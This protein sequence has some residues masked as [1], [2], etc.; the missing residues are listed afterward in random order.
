VSP[1]DEPTAAPAVSPRKAARSLVTQ[2]LIAELVIVALVGVFA[3]AGL[4]WTSASVIR[5]NLSHWASQWAGEL[6]ELGAPLYHDEREAVLG[7]E[8]FVAKYPEIDRVTWYRA[9]GSALTALD[10]TGVVDAAVAPLDPGLRAELAAKAG[11]DAPYLLTEDLTD[12]VR[13]RLSGPIRT[14][15]LAG[16][17]LFGFDPAAAPTSAELVGFVSVDIDFSAYE[18]AFLPRLALASGAL[19][20]LLGV[21]WACGRWF[22]KRALAPLSAL[23]QPLARLAAGDM[24]VQFPSSPHAELQAIVTALGDTI[25]A[26]HRRERHLLHLASHD[27]LT[28]LHN[29]HK[30]IEALDAEIA[31]CAAGKRRSALFF[32]DLDQFKYVNDTCGH[33]A[34]DEL[35]KLASRQI[36]HGVRAD[37]LVARFGGDEFVVLLRDVSRNDAKIVA[38]QVLELMRSL[39]H[40]EQDRVFHLQCSIGIAAINGH[41]FSAHE[42]IAQADIACQTAKQRGRNRVEVYS[43]AEKRSEQMAKDVDWM[44]SIRTALDNDGFVLYYQPLLHI[45]SGDVTH[46]EA[47]LRLKTEQG[48][49]SP[50]TFLPAA[51]RFGLMADIDRWVIARAVRSLAEFGAADA[52]LSL[53]VNL[54]SFAFENDDLGAYVRYLL[55]EHGVSGDKLTFEITEQLAVRF[56][57]KTDRQ[58]A[59]LRDLGCRIAIDDFGTGYSSFSYLKR[60]PVDFLKID[61]SFI[62]GLP[63]DR[64]DQSMVRMVGEV[65]RAAGMQTVAEYVHSAAALSL[66]AKYG[67]DYAQGFFIGRPAPKPQQVEIATPRAVNDDRE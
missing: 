12:G 26:L 3:L 50:Q 17:G 55:R 15:T 19:L 65:A 16:D 51:A 4:A 33:A 35:L 22:L 37:D 1:T 52:S 59:S 64:V 11:V 62:K 9:D 44:Q 24:D 54:S 46:Y 20:L 14:E 6:N 40:V 5:D 21:S 38:A 27:P 2:V 10:K 56:A 43:V 8:R 42:L 58:L 25:E 30:L 36:R 23:Q 63:R 41:R 28:G 57:V 66:L 7:V 49:V 18:R 67:I 61:G 60:L 32:I 34:G 47:L 53:G 13:F 45:R 29:R 48:L 31:E 39:K